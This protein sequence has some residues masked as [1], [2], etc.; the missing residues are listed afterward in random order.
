MAVNVL[1]DHLGIEDVGND[2]LVKMIFGA[3]ADEANIFGLKARLFFYEILHLIQCAQHLGGRH[4]GS[5]NRRFN[6]RDGLIS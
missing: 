2:N 4:N 5:P 1:R 6:D 3:F